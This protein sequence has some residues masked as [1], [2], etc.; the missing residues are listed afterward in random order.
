MGVDQ[1]QHAGLGHLAKLVAAQVHQLLLVDHLEAAIDEGLLIAL[2]LDRDLALHQQLHLAK[3]LDEGG[4]ARA[5]LLERFVERQDVARQLGRLRAVEQRIAL[6]ERAERRLN[7]LGFFKKVRIT[8]EPGSSPDRVIVVVDVEDQPT[9][10][11]G[12]SGGYSTTDGIIGE[13]SVSESNFQGRGQFVRVALTLGQRTRGIDFS[14]TEPYFMGY[15]MSAGFDLYHKQTLNS[16][17]SV[18]ESR[19]TGGA[20]RLGLPI[21]DEFSVGLRYSLYTTSISI[22]NTL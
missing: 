16:I 10:S 6:V 1:R 15:R 7:N 13:V 22:P 21:T 19:T 18:Y 4:G 11:F 14:F 9:G 20:L 5:G 2:V 8:N 3:L 17:Y 12:I